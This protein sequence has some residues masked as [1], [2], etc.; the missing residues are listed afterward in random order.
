LE[1]AIDAM[2][3][4]Y[5]QEHFEH[6]LSLGWLEKF[7]LRHG[8]KSFRR[9]GKSGSVDIQDMKTESESIRTKIDQF[10]MKDVFNMEKTSLFYRLYKLI[11]LLLRN[12]SK[13][14]SRTKKGS[15]LLFVAIKMDLKKIPL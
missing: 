11:I 3:L 4:L 8:I 5:P 12:N 2:K 1:K 15:Q 7:K 6:K 14:E 9:F 13:E 10:P